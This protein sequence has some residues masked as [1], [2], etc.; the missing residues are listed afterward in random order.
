MDNVR[1]QYAKPAVSVKINPCAGLNSSEV[2]SSRMNHGSNRISRKK[3]KS[4][5]AQ[6]ISN[7]GDPIIRILIIALAINIVFM[8]RDI[9]WFETV[10][11][12]FA[13]LLAALVS[14]ISEYGSGLAF[15]RLCKDSENSV[16]RVIRDGQVVEISADDIVAGDV[17]FLNPGDIVPADGLMCRGEISV[18]QSALTGESMEEN[19]H[20][21]PADIDGDLRKNAVLDEG[22]IEWGLEKKNLMFRGSS[23]T[24][25]EGEMKV[26]RVGDGT[27][28]GNVAAKIQEQTRP[29]PLK[30]RLSTLASSVSFLGYLCA[31]M[32]AFA[33]LFNV[34]AIDSGMNWAIMLGR[35]RDVGYV[36]SELLHALTLAVSVIVVAVPEG[37]PMMITVVLSSNMKRML[38]DNVLVRKLVGI[39]TAGNLNILF[40]DKTGT[41]TTGNLNV[42]VIVKGDGSEYNTIGKVK[43]DAPLFDLMCLSAQYNSTSS[44]SK[45]Y[46]PNTARFNYAAVGGNA[47]DRA[48]LGYALSSDRFE[49]REFDVIEKIPFDSARK[50]SAVRIKSAKREKTSLTLIKGAPELILP[51]AK[52]YIADDGK[53]RRMSSMEMMHLRKRWNELAKSAYR[54]IAVAC[55]DGNSPLPADFKNRET[56]SNGEISLKEG[57]TLVCLVGIRDEIRREVK[58]AVAQVK[59]AGIR[60][61][62]ITGDNETTAEAVAKECGIMGTLRANQMKK[63]SNRRMFSLHSYLQKNGIPQSEAHPRKGGSLILTGTDMAKLSDDELTKMLPNIAV[64]ARALPSDKSRLISISQRAGLVAGM[65][66]DGI[67]DAPALT[68]ADVGFSMGSGTDVAKEAGDIVILDNNFA[69]I[70]KA[71]LYGRTIFE[72]IR[73]FILFQLTMNFSALGVSLIGPFIGIESPVTVAQM[74]WINIIM[75][76]LGGLAFAGEPPLPEYMTHPPKLMDEKILTPTMI[77]GIFITGA[78]TVAMC[79]SFLKIPAIHDF[80]AYPY[81]STYL[82][83]AFFALFIFSGIFNCFN[84]RTQR[85]NLAAHIGKNRPFILI[86]LLISTIQLLLIYTGGTFFRTVPLTYSDLLLT[87]AMAAAVIPVDIVRKIISRRRSRRRQAIIS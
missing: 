41:L 20:P 80:L 68:A 17:V 11:I 64:I 1:K 61:I 42:S 31:G 6:F 25:G 48:L 66:G 47:T 60:V 19:K 59:G 4:F 13:I 67:N 21:I 58:S 34:F 77:R 28:Y 35:L 27:F 53:P 12:A 44:V 29:S 10:G 70:A 15:E 87:I 18:N 82:L 73:K 49:P 24:S 38:R 86:M 71:V 39:E 22:E 5:F 54:V 30:Q 14:T 84:A 33:Y 26:L 2:L 79:I 16:C 55:A 50:Y 63:S 37:L 69:S 46:A 45:F 40:T 9:N 78:F 75:D 3:R 76:T 72:S 23:V 81:D 7:L 85:V 56:A 62:M 57:T 51:S 36:A 65:T 32:I 83:T 8:I 74:L 43:N 52:Y